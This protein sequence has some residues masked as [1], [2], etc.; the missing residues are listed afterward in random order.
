[1]REIN[2]SPNIHHHISQEPVTKLRHVVAKSTAFRTQKQFSRIQGPGIS[3]SRSRILEACRRGTILCDPTS[4]LTGMTCREYV[5][6][7]VTLQPKQKVLW[8]IIP[9]SGPSKMQDHF[10]LWTIRHCW[11]KK[12]LVV[13]KPR[14]TVYRNT[15]R[16]HQNTV[17]WGTLKLAQRKGLQFY[18][19]RSHAIALFQHTSCDL[20]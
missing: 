11:E 2:V 18:Q 9:S 15:W 1:M 6:C 12:I 16:V 7:V 4:D 13:D 17:Y 3:F 8:E 20:Y 10:T 19:T 5:P 14:I